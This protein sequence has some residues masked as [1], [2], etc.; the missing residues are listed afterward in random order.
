M[1]KLLVVISSD[2]YVRN[3]L[4]TNALRELE[5]S[6]E[7]HFAGT[8]EL[9]LREEIEKKAGFQG[10][11]GMSKR[12]K[13]LHQLHF[14]L[15]MWR[16]RKK[17]KTFLYRWMRNSN[18]HKIDSLHGPLR[19]VTSAVRWLLSAALNPQGL[20]VPLLGN[21]I[22]FP[23]STALIRLLLPVDDDL[24]R[25]V[26]TEK[27]DAI[28][29]PSAAF[30]PVS[31][32]LIRIGKRL[33]VTTLCLIDN[34]DNLTSKTVFWTKPNHLG[35]WGEQ[36]KGQAIDIHDFPP[37]HVHTIGT[38]RFDQYLSRRGR[39][40]EEEIY[41]FPYILFVGSAM[42][43]DEI[44][45]LHNLEESLSLNQDAPKDLRIVYR[46][47]PWQQKRLVS[48]TFEDRDF[49]QVILDK[50]ISESRGNQKLGNVSFQPD[51]TYYPKLLVGARC[52]VGPLTTMLLEASICLKPVIAL[53]FSDGVHGTTT[54]TY[55]SHF[56]GAERIPG[57]NFCNSQ[58]ELP[59]LLSAALSFGESNE[60]ESDEAISTYVNLAEPP[61]PSRLGNLVGTILAKTSEA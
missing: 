47:H 8:L 36:A 21:R 50:Q 30:E 58:D 55:F 33:N 56:E 9:S 39:K 57:F 2:L 51:L 52:V 46:P 48:S 11:F 34:W 13:R 19:L 4:R 45:M 60:V 59:N 41:A 15:M 53:N 42:P 26:Q 10:L 37:H 32:D 24:S 5:E 6:F 38:P 20:I 14:N 28:V 61:Y 49:T 31:V 25:L 1:A 3:Y 17:S 18:W 43:F 12:L 44:R 27:Y 16:H 40:P 7:C 35:V 54:K 22:L 29:F 23:I